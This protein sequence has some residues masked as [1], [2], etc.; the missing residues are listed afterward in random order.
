M[1]REHGKLSRSGQFS[2]YALPPS[3]AWPSAPAEHPA[4]KVGNIAFIS[5]GSL[6]WL[7]PILGLHLL[8]LPLNTVRLM[9]MPRVAPGAA[10][11][12]PRLAMLVD[13]PRRGASA[14][15]GWRY[16]PR[17]FSRT[18]FSSSSSAF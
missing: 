5:Y 15:S 13:R 14:G 10:Q 17:S 12:E 4:G 3:T 11:R 16:E 18:L 6:M 7:P 8:L 9:G 1:P 2:D